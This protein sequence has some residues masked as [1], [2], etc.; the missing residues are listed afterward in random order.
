LW[1]NATGGGAWGWGATKTIVKPWLSTSFVC[2]EGASETVAIIHS[3]SN[4]VPVTATSTVGA[5][6]SQGSAV[7]GT[8]IVGYATQIEVG[9][10]AT[11]SGSVVTGTSTV[12]AERTSTF[13]EGAA[14][15]GSSVSASADVAGEA[16]QTSTSRIGGV[17]SASGTLSSSLVAFTGGASS[18]RMPSTVLGLGAFAA[19]W[20]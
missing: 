17:A 16:T 10:T 13:V 8:E 7:G 4:G 2:P 18:M 9:Y 20:L 14:S 15:S 6:A 3:L 5:V 12:G 11:I 1:S 19:W